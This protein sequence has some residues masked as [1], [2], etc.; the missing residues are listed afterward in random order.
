MNRRSFCAKLAAIPFVGVLFAKLVPAKTNPY[1]NLRPLSESPHMAAFAKRE[2]E[3]HFSVIE[4]YRK[5]DGYIERSVS[6]DGQMVSLSKT[7]EMPFVVLDNNLVSEPEDR[8]KNVTVNKYV[9]WSEV[10]RINAKS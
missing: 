7:D 10:E 1:L 4:C 2:L 3:R 5:M 8:I 9:P 6:V